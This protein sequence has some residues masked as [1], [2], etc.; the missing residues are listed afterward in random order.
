MNSTLQRCGI[1]SAQE[2]TALCAKF[3]GT[4]IRGKHN[5]ITPKTDPLKVSRIIQMRAEG[6]KIRDIAAELRIASSTIS[7]ILNGRGK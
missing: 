4:G 6:R 7:Y 3:F 2:T 1:V 5:S